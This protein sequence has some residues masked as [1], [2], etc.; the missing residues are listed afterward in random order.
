MK[1]YDRIVLWLDYFNSRLS[2]DQGRRVPLNIAVS[3][4]TL[5]ELVESVKRLGFEAEVVKARHP[6]RSYVESG[7][8]SIRKVKGKNV[9][10]KEVSKTL[11]FVRG[12]KRQKE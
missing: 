10:L 6:K 5:D 4:P 11:G 12:M 7:Y 2:R 1:D 8:V 3:S 9:V